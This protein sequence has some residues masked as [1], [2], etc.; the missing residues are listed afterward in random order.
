[1]RKVKKNSWYQLKEEKC[2]NC[3]AGLMRDM[4]RKEYTGCACGFNVD[5]STKDLLVTRD[6]QDNKQEHGSEVSNN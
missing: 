4:F 2:P 5:N 6:Y 1:M 3:G